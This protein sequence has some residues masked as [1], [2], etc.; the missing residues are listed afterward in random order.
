MGAFEIR[1]TD[2]FSEIFAVLEKREQEWIE[3]IVEKL[4][5]NPFSGKPIRFEWFREKKFEDKRLYFF[6]SNPKKRI[7]IIAFGDI[8]KRK[9]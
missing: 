3:K 8:W 4:K 5:T 1:K 9:K 2:T 7:L 6:V